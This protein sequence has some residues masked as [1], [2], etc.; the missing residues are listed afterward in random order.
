MNSAGI[1]LEEAGVPQMRIADRV[2]ETGAVESCSRSGSPSVL[3][4]DPSCFSLPYDYSLCEALSSRGCAVT[5]VRSEF[6]HTPWQAATSFKVWNHFYERSHA[7]PRSRVT[8]PLWKLGKLAEHNRDMARLVTECEKQKPDIVHFQWLPIPMIDRRYLRKLRR[9]APLV[10]TLHN[11]TTFHGSLAQRLHQEVGF[12]SIFQHLSG[13]IVHT[14]FSKR[15][16]I[17][18]G[19]LP[20]EKIHVVR[21]GV[22]DHY[23]SVTSA[24]PVPSQELGA[25]PAG[26]TVLFFGAIEN[27]KGVDLLI[28]AFAGLPPRMQSTNRLCIAGKPGRDMSGLK[29]LARSLNIEQR[30]SWNLRF[31]AEEEVPGLFRSAAV[32]VLPYREIDQSGVLMTAIAFDKPI[33][34]SRIGGLAE[35]IQDGVHGRLFPA[36]DVPALTAALEEVLSHPERRRDMEKAVRE[37]RESISWENSADR[38][39]DVYEQLLS[40]S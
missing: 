34:A 11:T 7:R 10:L 17:E 8:G 25:E 5:L 19:W 40:G 32:V 4:V 30:I 16:V 35:T 12:G 9:I 24:A 2:V 37:L 28:R 38:T 33:I 18:R 23:R 26:P 39:I 20:A 14:E 6:V 1:H 13:L 31:V 21:H 36:G 15:I 27:Y 3:V 22:L 29:E